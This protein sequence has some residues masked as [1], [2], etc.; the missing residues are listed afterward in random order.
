VMSNFPTDPVWQGLRQRLAS[1]LEALRIMDL[2]GTLYDDE[3]VDD[4]DLAALLS[5]SDGPESD[6]GV[7]YEDP[8]HD[9]AI[10]HTTLRP[11]RVPGGN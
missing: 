4:D 3:E 8:G 2:Q 11:R 5:E 9:T 10:A 7:I 6:A 1:S